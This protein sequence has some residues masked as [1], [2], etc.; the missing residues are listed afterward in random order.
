MGEKRIHYIVS[1]CGEGQSLFSESLKFDST[2]R[3]NFDCAV[4]IPIILIEFILFSTY[5]I[6]KMTTTQFL[7]CFLKKKTLE[8]K[9][10]R[11]FTWGL[12]MQLEKLWKGYL[13]LPKGE[14]SVSRYR[15]AT[16]NFCEFQPLSELLSYRGTW[17]DGL[18]APSCMPR[19]QTGCKSLLQD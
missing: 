14:V 5:I 10:T 2:W 11:H 18:A 3:D 8:L 16:L 7:F 13:C 4:Y 12:G 1:I 9:A 17:H 15:E 19:S 6:I